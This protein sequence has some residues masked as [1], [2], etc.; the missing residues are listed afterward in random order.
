M[1]DYSSYTQ[2]DFQAMS[3]KE[4]E[5]YAKQKYKK[6]MDFITHED[7]YVSYSEF[8]TELSGMMGRQDSVRRFN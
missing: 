8:F 6:Y 5:K 4:F 2:A 7:D 1:K 3:N